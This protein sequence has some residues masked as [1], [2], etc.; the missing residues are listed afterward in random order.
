MKANNIDPNS[1]DIDFLKQEFNRFRSELAGMKDKLGGNAS[2]ALDQM[3]AYLN[4]GGLSSR[5]ASLESELEYIAGKLKDTGK[6]A[7]T[8]LER[9]V[10][11]RPIASIGI[12]FGIGLLASQFFRRS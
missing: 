11:K 4:G 7:M 10:G 5:V 6:G 3:S 12:A 8:N 2:E 9:E 1:I